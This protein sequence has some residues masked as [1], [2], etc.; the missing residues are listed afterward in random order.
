[1]EGEQ[2]VALGVGDITAPEA[3]LIISRVDQAAN[4][5]NYEALEHENETVV[6]PNLKGI[7]VSGFGPMHL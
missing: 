4:S 2:R 3:N 5:R 6:Q 1:M 7:L